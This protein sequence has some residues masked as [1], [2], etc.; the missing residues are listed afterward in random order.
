MKNWLFVFCLLT[1]VTASAATVP[2]S[3]DITA[4]LTT[5]INSTSSGGTVDISAG[6]CSMS[7]MAAFTDKNITIR[8]AG[9]GVTNITANNGFATFN[10]SGANN[11]KF[12]ITG[13]SF[14]GSGSPVWL[15]VFGTHSPLLRGGFRIDHVSLNYPGS[16]ADGTIQIWGPL[17]GLIDHCDF[18]QLYEAAL[19]TSFEIDTENCSYNVGGTCTLS[20]LSG[21]ASAGLPFEPGSGR[22]LYLE[23][24]TF[25][26]LS[27]N[28]LVVADTAYAGQRIVIRNNT[29]NNSILYN[30]WTGAGTV[31]SAWWEAYNNKFS[32][33]LG[34]DGGHF[35]MRIQGGG[36][37]LIYNNTVTGFPSYHLLVGDGRLPDQGQSGAPNNYCDGRQPIDGNAGDPEAPGWPC[38]AQTGRAADKSISQIIGGSKQGSF[39][40]YLWNNGP[41]LSCSN[42]SA[43]GAACDNSLRVNT[44][45][46]MAAKYFKSTP[47]V[48]PG[49]GNGDVDYSI[50]SS[51]PNGA[52]TH[53]LNYTPFPYP[54]PLDAQGFPVPGATAPPATAAHPAD[55]DKNSKMTL[56]EATKYGFCWKSAPVMSAGCPANASLDYAVRA[57]TL[58]SSSADGSYNFDSTKNPPLCWV[59]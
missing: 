14:S 12:R 34:S 47:H 4:A 1:S 55:I 31:N 16:G 21:G 32:W 7:K 59:P 17:Y 26:G 39:P 23:D 36:T 30:H 3:G 27:S 45:S 35:P 33:T 43:G 40:L 50:T 49:Y 22:N 42:P 9:K 5:A 11:P 29:M 10:V 53:T 24:N 15:S 2:C 8:G 20:T 56:D 28:P 58:W 6:S 41:Q 52:G 44:Y 37:G 38:L 48:T 19:L 46:P 57:G 13:M 25:T 51:K 18:T 54:Y